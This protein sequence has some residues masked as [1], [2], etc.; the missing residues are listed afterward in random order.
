LMASFTILKSLAIPISRVNSCSWFKS[1][2]I[3]SMMITTPDRPHINLFVESL[4]IGTHYIHSVSNSIIWSCRTQCLCQ[5]LLT[6][7]KH[8]LFTSPEKFIIIWHTIDSRR[9]SITLSCSVSSSFTWVGN[10][11]TFVQY[12][13]FSWDNSFHFTIWTWF[14][15]STISYSW[16]ND[17]DS[18]L[19]SGSEMWISEYMVANID[20]PPIF[21]QR[22]WRPSDIYF[23]NH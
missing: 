2:D 3:W 7:I 19:I 10:S 18:H 13:H 22:N 12:I 5:Y 21:V 9:T 4:E 1:N 8:P 20:W 16:A 14:S 15:K 17:V 6:M 11:A 23:P